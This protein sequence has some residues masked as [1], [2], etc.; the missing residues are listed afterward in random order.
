[1][2][3]G[4]IHLKV[5][6]GPRAEVCVQLKLAID[7]RPKSAKQAVPVAFTKMLS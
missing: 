1:M 3:S 5:P 6:W 4:A 2:S 7:E